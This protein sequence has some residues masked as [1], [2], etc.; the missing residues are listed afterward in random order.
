MGKIRALPAFVLILV[1]AAC[2]ARENGPEAGTMPTTVQVENQ[3]FLDMTVY[4]LDGTQRVRIGM[5]PG[6]STRTLQI[7]ER[8]VF[9]VS[10]LRFQVDPVGSQRAPISQ[11]ITVSEGQA[12]RLIIPPSVR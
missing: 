10:S 8:L 6:N 4:V 2:A 1:L 7:P 3:A 12:L 5:V 11:E 9:G